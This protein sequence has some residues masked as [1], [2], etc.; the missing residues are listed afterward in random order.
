MH[1]QLRLPGS[2]KRC[3]VEGMDPEGAD[4]PLCGGAM[5][6]KATT[7]Y[8][9]IAIAIETATAAET[10]NTGSARKGESAGP[11]DIAQ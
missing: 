9:R 8:E 10:E 3:G 5:K 11:K 6:V 4:C 2:R 7:E 1:G